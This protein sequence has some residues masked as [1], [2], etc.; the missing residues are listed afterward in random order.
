MSG[1][2][3]GTVSDLRLK[4][5]KLG[6][7]AH[8][9]FKGQLEIS[10]LPDLKSTYLHFDAKDL[11]A[12]YYDLIQL[13]AYPFTE[14]KSLSIPEQLKPLGTVAYRGKFDGFLND[15]TTYGTFKTAIGKLKTD[16]SIK[17]PENNEAISYHGKINSENFD[18]GTLLGQT[19]FNHLSM[20]LELEG[21]G[22]EP[23]KPRS[24]K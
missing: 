16:L 23:K 7:G 14:G 15:F 12:N 1:K 13:P 10:G 19:D 6:Y 20:N 18:L 8:T 9:G 17:I 22:I 3:N 11:T 5:F 2:V 24:G 21:K 4:N